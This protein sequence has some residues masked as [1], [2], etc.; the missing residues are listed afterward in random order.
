MAIKNGRCANCG[1]IIRFDDRNEYAVCP[2]C[3]AKTEGKTALD[4]EANPKKYTFLNEPQEEL[5]EEDAALAMVGYKSKDSAAAR[6]ARLTAEASRARSKVDAQPTAAERVAALRS[7][8]IEIPKTTTKQRL[9]IGGGIVLILGLLVGISLPLVI[10]RDNMRSQLETKIGEISVFE[11][12]DDDH[13]AFQG[14][15]NDKLVVVAPE[16][17]EDAEALRMFDNF[18][19][20]RAEAYQLESTDEQST[21]TLSVL[22]EDGSVE[23]RRGEVSVLGD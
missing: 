8:P 6:K 2:F 23:V 15:K 11:I 7:K 21:L 13:Y 20:S 1:S 5:S 3:N 19:K 16:R 10:R 22:S 12:E 18:K 9:L 17:L 14:L 4:I